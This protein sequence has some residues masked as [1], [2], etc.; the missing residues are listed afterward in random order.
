M[1][2]CNVLGKQQETSMN[3]VGKKSSNFVGWYLVANTRTQIN[4]FPLAF[5]KKY[6]E[7]FARMQG[8]NR[9]LLV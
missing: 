9:L 3:Y 8:E 1:S 4:V 7:R 2:L 5:V 6:K